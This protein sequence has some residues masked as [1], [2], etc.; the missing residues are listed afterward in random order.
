MRTRTA[1]TTATIVGLAA[2]L[3]LA[4][5]ISAQGASRGHKL[6]AGQFSKKDFQ[7]VKA[8]ARGGMMEVELGKIAQEKGAIPAVQDFGKRMVTD[9]SQINTELKELATSKGATL[10]AMLLRKQRRQVQHLEGLS[11]ARFDRAYAKDMVRD[12]K[13]DIKAFEKAAKHAKNPE[14]RAF[15]QKTVSILKEHLRLAQEMEASVNSGAWNSA[16]K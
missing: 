11:P 4:P 1:I 3:S 16:G 6:Q 13:H 2:V 14:L 15:A 8:A 7:F 12:H 9:H 5:A 10:P